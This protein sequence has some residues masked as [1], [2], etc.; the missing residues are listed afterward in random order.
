IASPGNSGTMP[1]TATSIGGIRS[2]SVKSS[3]QNPTT[4]AAIAL[5][6]AGPPTSSRVAQNVVHATAPA[7]AASPTARGRAWEAS[8][9]NPAIPADAASSTAN[10][11]LEG[12]AETTFIGTRARRAT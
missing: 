6:T 9:Q 4:T 3:P 11:T 1:Q 12:A 8:A 2:R 10:G 5:A 7:S